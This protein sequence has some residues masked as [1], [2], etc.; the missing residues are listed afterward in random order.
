M[1]HDLERLDQCEIEIPD[2]TFRQAMAALM[3]LIN[4]MACGSEIRSDL[5][6]VPL[7]GKSGDLQ[8]WGPASSAS[9]RSC[10]TR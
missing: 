6:V 8:V 1:G 2:V 9:S 5:F 10:G 3:L 4:A 7:T